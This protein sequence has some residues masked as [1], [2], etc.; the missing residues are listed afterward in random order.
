MKLNNNEK[1]LVCHPLRVLLQ[2]KIEAPRVLAALEDRHIN[3]CI[4]IGCGH[5]IGALLISS[6]ISCRHMVGLDMD[7]GMI[8]AAR[9]TVVNPPQWAAQVRRNSIEFVCGDALS[10]AF[11]DAR[12]D[13][14]VMFG[15]LNTIRG[16]PRVLSEVYRILKPGGIFSFKEALIP[17]RFLCFSRLTGH[18][19]VID[20]R[21]LQSA[22]ECCNFEI[23]RFDVF[24]QM[25]ACFVQATKPDSLL[26]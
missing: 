6:R 4:E 3:S 14:A 26:P 19:P 16:W 25:P 15:V 1:R 11:G 12:F 24:K 10:L 21:A 8:A 20:R 23:K 5:G 22:L 9:Q 18:V 13:A 2:R 17:D 7:P